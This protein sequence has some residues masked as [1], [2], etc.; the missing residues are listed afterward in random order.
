MNTKLLDVLQT[1]TLQNDI[2]VP[3]AHWEHFQ[4][5]QRHQIEEGLFSVFSHLG[6]VICCETDENPN[7]YMPD[8]IDIVLHVL[9]ETEWEVDD[10]YSEDDWENAIIELVHTSGKSYKFTVEA[11]DNSHWIPTQFITKLQQ[12]SHAE[13][14]KSLVVFYSEDSFVAI[15]LSHE[16]AKGLEALIK[17]YT[18]KY[19]VGSTLQ[20]IF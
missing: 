14:K 6:E 17:S 9:K 8:V 12:F 5:G 1:F 3:K 15:S 16:V 13:C 10:V 4:E 19:P 18:K 20:P 7:S 11:V 2:L